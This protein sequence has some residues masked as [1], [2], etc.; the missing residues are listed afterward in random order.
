M[1]AIFNEDDDDHD[2]HDYGHPGPVTEGTLMSSCVTT[3]CSRETLHQ[4]HLVKYTDCWFQ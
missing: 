2:D 1:A 4:L 3:N